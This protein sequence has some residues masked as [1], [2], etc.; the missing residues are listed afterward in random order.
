MVLSLVAYKREVKPDTYSNLN[1]KLGQTSMEGIGNRVLGA[2][3]LYQGDKARLTAQTTPARPDPWGECR[4]GLVKVRANFY[5]QIL[6][7]SLVTTTI[8]IKPK[9]ADL[10]YGR[11]PL[12]KRFTLEEARAE[13]LKLKEL[14]CGLVHHQEGY[15][16]RTNKNRRKGV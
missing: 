4:R 1:G 13:A 3:A 12:P 2:A 9:D 14:H 5:E 16:I 11:I 15:A 10:S 6:A 8:E 7:K